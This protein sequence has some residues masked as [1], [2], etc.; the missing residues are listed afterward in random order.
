MSP[1]KRLYR[2][3]P[4]TL[5]QQLVVYVLLPVFVAA[6]LAIGFTGYW[7][8]DFTRDNLF[9]KVRG[10]VYLAQYALRQVKQKRYLADLQ[11]FA[12]S[13]EV[14]TAVARGAAIRLGHLRRQFMHDHG[15]SF[16]H[17]TG[18]LGT[19][20]Y[21]KRGGP[22]RTS[23]PTLLTARALRNEPAAA[24]EVFNHADLTREGPDVVRHVQ[25][26]AP[27][28]R[29]DGHPWDLQALVL[30]AVVPIRDAHGAIV[31]ALDGGVLLNNQPE[32]LNAVREQVYR[33]G[34]L[35]KDGR[36]VV[37]LILNDVRIDSSNERG[38]APSALLG[39]RV[40]NRIRD[41]VVGAGKVVVAED[42]FGAHTYISAYAPL[43]DVHAQSVGM[44]QVGFD[45]APFSAIY[46]RA[47]ALLFLIVL[48]VTSLATVIAFR[49]VRFVTTPIERITEVVRATQAGMDRRIGSIASSSEIRELGRQ[50][51]VMLDQ[52]QAR[53]EEIQRAAAELEQK[54]QDRTR[55]L[56]RKNS[57]L[58]ETV[59][60][61][62]ETRHRLVVN[63]KLAALGELAAGIAHEINNPASVLIG[64]LD[65]LVRDLGPATQPVRDEIELMVQQV[66]RIRHIVNSLMQFARPAK[67]V[68]DISR[69]DVNEVVR[70][71]IALVRHATDKKA[72]Q[73]KTDLRA[74][75]RIFVNVYE[76]EQVL[77]N[78][79]LNAVRVVEQDGRIGIETRD[80]DDGGIVIAVTDNG[81]GI[82]EKDTHR[83]FDPFFTTN[84]EGNTG[85]GLSVS[86]AIVNRYGGELSV[87]SK[88]GQGT[89]FYVRLPLAREG[90]VFG[91]TVSH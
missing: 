70:D 78:L 40:R 54:V 57:D 30:R 88:P 33:S 45:E 27:Y 39:T 36:A 23:K 22:D 44:L 74:D 79:V 4:T 87:E 63:E 62:N 75:N 46:F 58:E 32:I 43:Y 82:S 41:A 3:G 34:S 28:F 20:M 8:Y 64:N 9:R 71:T 81:P 56:A 18:P 14:R 59:L 16:V 7:F 83:L 61:L 5:R 31:A 49:G 91:V 1:W 69:A 38:V 66:D 60:L 17:I 42:V 53:N 21:E 73:L 65:L 48:S 35:P 52:L 10:D 85:L 6:T 90:T 47:A 67:A 24:I 77:I 50:F 29:R 2:P 84:P 13:Y 37:G 11:R 55:E 86:Y 72:V 80:L 12:D 68:G 19:W 26:M 89:T 51:D 25:A 76:L 15:F